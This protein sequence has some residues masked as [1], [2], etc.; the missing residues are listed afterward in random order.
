MLVYATWRILASYIGI[1]AGLTACIIAE[2][3]NHWYKFSPKGYIPLRNFYK[4]W[5]GVGSP[6]SVQSREI[7]PL[8]LLKCGLR[9]PEIVKIGNFSYKFAQ[10]G[11]TPLSNF[12]KIWLG[13]GSPRSA[14]S[15]QIL[16]LWLYKCGLAARKIAEIVNFWYI[17]SPKVV[18]PFN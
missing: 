9:A 11:Y 16:P 13:G 15:R 14:P 4:I 18:N 3:N 17:F 10:K 2:N 7:S 8:W 6:R 12:Y 5:R 1:A